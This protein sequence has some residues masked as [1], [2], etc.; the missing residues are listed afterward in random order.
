VSLPQNVVAGNRHLGFRKDEV[1]LLPLWE[2]LPVLR[3]CY[4]R[5]LSPEGDVEDVWQNHLESALEALDTP[6][7]IF[8]SQKDWDLFLEGQRNIASGWDLRHTITDADR[9]FLAALRIAWDPETMRHASW[10]A[11]H[12]HDDDF[13]FNETH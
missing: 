1:N 13:L 3:R 11:S 5:L 8:R 4:V 2:K 9:R 6:H 12:G 10:R 7:R